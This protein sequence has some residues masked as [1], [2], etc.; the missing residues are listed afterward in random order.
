MLTGEDEASNNR[1]KKML[2]MEEKK[3]NPCKRTIEVL[4]TRTFAFRRRDILST[5]KALDEVLKE[6]PS[7]KRLDQVAKSNN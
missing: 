5:P 7:L 1:N 6:F 4:M 2:I 3:L